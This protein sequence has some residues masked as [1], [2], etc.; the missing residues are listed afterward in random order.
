VRGRVQ[1]D[2]THDVKDGPGFVNQLFVQWQ[3]NG[4]RTVVWPKELATGKM[5]NPPWLSN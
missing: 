1:F 4:E 5:I 3:D 2:Q